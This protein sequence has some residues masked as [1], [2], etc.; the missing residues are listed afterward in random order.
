MWIVCKH[1]KFIR[2][3]LIRADYPREKYYMIR[4]NLLLTKRASIVI[5]SVKIMLFFVKKKTHSLFGKTTR[6]YI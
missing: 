6:S 4:G 1:E 3:V 5:G 2:A